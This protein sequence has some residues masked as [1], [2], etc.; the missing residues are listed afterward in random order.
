MSKSLC[1]FGLANGTVDDGAVSGNA[2][3][4]G[5]LIIK[6]EVDDIE[7]I[8]FDGGAIDVELGCLLDADNE[9]IK[10]WLRVAGIA[11]MV[12][13]WVVDIVVLDVVAAATAD[14]DDDA[15]GIGDGMSE[16]GCTLSIS[17]LVMASNKNDN[18]ENR[19]NLIDMNKYT[20]QKSYTYIFAHEAREKEKIGEDERNTI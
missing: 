8:P 11:V 19:L 3:D 6:C 13:L 1:R 18:I 9:L 2:I 12:G 7:L 17:G 5:E 15:N 20:K 4:G 10:R 16:D 14:D